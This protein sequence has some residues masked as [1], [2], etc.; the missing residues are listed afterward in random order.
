MIKAIAASTTRTTRAIRSVCP[1]FPVPAPSDIGPPRTLADLD[2]FPV[3]YTTRVLGACMEPV[4]PDRAEAVFSKTAAWK[5]GDIVAVWMRPEL[6]GPGEVQSGVKVLTM[7]PP[8]YVKAFPFKDHPQSNVAALFFLES[9]NPR[10]RFMVRCADVLAIHKFVGIADGAGKVISGVSANPASTASARP[11]PAAPT[12]GCTWQLGFRDGLAGFRSQA[13]AGG[14]R[15]AYSSGYL[16][17]K[18][19][20]SMIL[21]G[22]Q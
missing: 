13:P 14:D 7:A 16:E 3:E 2:A 12:E 5:V 22:V 10:Q 20:R 11:E 1:T 6:V 21:G 9:L 17:G 19:Q 4:I 18:A 15:P 8:F